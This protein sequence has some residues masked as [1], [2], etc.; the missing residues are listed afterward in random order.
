M[1]MLS[2]DRK[3]LR[4]VLLRQQKSNNL[5]SINCKLRQDLA[6]Y[7]FCLD[8]AMGVQFSL[9]I[10]DPSASV[11]VQLEDKIVRYEQNAALFSASHPLLSYQCQSLS[12]PK[13]TSKNVRFLKK[14]LLFL[15]PTILS[16]KIQGSGMF[17]PSSGHSIARPNLMSSK[18]KL[19]EN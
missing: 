7:M 11:H 5:Q 8:Y 9:A 16:E 4:I 1:E 18:P 3:F 17:A 12:L 14:K 19:K 13:S 15:F 6:N 10:I 2:N